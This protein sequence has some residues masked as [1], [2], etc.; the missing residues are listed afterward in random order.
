VRYLYEC[1]TS[2]DVWA[3]WSDVL[4]AF[5]AAFLGASLG[6]LTG[7]LTRRREAYLKEEVAVNNLLLDLAA[8]RA[9]AVDRTVNW[10]P[11]AGGRIQESVNH[12][13]TLIRDA[14]L[15]LRPRS[16]FLEPI[17][18]MMLSCNTFIEQSEYRAGGP[19]ASDLERL[20]NEVRAEARMMHAVRP[21]RIV[22]DEPGT[23]AVSRRVER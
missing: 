22:D 17:R 23:L 9:F 4:L 13:R 16:E 5:L 18:M 12:T 3:A 1:A 6:L 11:G 15:S 19:T 20:T 2:S 8:K 7:W 21:K 10:A 14:R